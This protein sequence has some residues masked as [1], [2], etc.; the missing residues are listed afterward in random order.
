MAKS[1]ISIIFR[2]QFFGVRLPL[3]VTFSPHKSRSS[4]RSIIPSSL[5]SQLL[6]TPYSKYLTSC[7]HIVLGF[8]LLLFF[9]LQSICMSHLHNQVC[10]N[11]LFHNWTVIYSVDI[12]HLV[13]PFTHQQT[14]GFCPCSIYCEW[15][16][17]RT[18][19]CKY[20]LQAAL[21]ILLSLCSEKELLDS[22]VI[23]LLIFWEPNCHTLF[24]LIIPTQKA[25]EFQ[26]LSGLGLFI[27][28]SASLV[29]IVIGS[30]SL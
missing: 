3:S 14:L 27:I 29:D 6:A 11:F 17:C 19:V 26:F 24:L 10:Q 9:A 13:Y 22:L 8:L 18:W 20:L 30:I 28:S 4:H 5:S 23:P 7:S 15:L 16:Y 21:S 25:S 1:A 2:V 12:P